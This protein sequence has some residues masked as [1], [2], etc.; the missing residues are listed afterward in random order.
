MLLAALVS[1]AC[2]SLTPAGQKVL[3]TSN[4]DTVKGCR[5]LGQVKGSDHMWGGAAGQGAAEDNATTRLKNKTAEMGGNVVFLSRSSTGF[6]G[7]SQLGEAYSC[8]NLPT[9]L[10]R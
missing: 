4:P 3:I 7:S 9:P 8:P 1:S 10:S 2:S 6:S 5:L